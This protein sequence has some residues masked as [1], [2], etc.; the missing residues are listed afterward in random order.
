MINAKYTDRKVSGHLILSEITGLQIPVIYLTDIF[1]NRKK[2][3]MIIALKK[4]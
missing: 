4:L 3:T 2:I 1:K